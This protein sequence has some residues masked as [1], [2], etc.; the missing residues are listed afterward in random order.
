MARLSDSTLRT[1]RFYEEAGLLQ[2]V[3]RTEGG[4]RLFPE[5]ELEKLRLVGDLREAGFA[6]DEIRELCAL[7]RQAPTGGEASRRMVARLDQQIDAMTGRIGLLERL[8]QELEQARRVLERCA[9][10]QDP[11]HFPDSCGECRVM[12]RGDEVPAAVSVLWELER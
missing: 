2:P 12:K 10:C 6:L 1:V 9:G 5:S 7:K 11:A 4:H 3:Q 8:K